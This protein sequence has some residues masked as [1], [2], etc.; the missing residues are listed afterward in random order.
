MG[1]VGFALLHNKNPYQFLLTFTS[2]TCSYSLISE[3]YYVESYQ[4]TSVYFQSYIQQSVYLQVR[5]Q[6]PYALTLIATQW[7]WSFISYGKCPEIPFF[8]VCY[9]LL[10]HSLSMISFL[11]PSKPRD[12]WNAKLI[13]LRYHFLA[14]WHDYKL[15]FC[16]LA[17]FPAVFFPPFMIRL[18]DLSL[19]ITAAEFQPHFGAQNRS[20][21]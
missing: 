3:T 10:D 20:Y 18:A 7:C 6:A 17:P 15:F 8:H 11:P 9:L 1:G 4:I 13:L 19:Q 21:S 14:F 12:Y 2:S 16:L 5:H